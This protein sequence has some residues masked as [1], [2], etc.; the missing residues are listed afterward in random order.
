MARQQQPDGACSLGGVWVNDENWVWVIEPM[1]DRPM[2]SH[3]YEQSE[4]RFQRWAGY[5]LVSVVPLPV[6]LFRVHAK[7]LTIVSVALLPAFMLGVITPVVFRRRHHPDRHLKAERRFTSLALVCRS[8]A[9]VLGV[10]AL[11]ALAMDSPS[12]TETGM[13]S[14][15]GGV[16]IFAIP[17]FV[18]K[19]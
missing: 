15:I 16:I 19:R 2:T 5:V 3:D 14:A 11:I 9:F 13:A 10:T 12:A 17:H 6:L 8:L 18:A 1:S 4:R 7:P